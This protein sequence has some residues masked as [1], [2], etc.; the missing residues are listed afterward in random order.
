MLLHIDVE[1]DYYLTVDENGIYRAGCREFTKEEALEHWRLENYSNSVFMEYSKKAAKRSA[2]YCKAILNGVELKRIPDDL[3]YFTFYAHMSVPENLSTHKKLCWL[4]I[5]KGA[6]IPEGTVLP[7][8]L[9][10]IVVRRDAK[11][12]V[13]VRIPESVNR[14][15]LHG[16]AILRRTTTIPESCEIKRF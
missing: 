3:E 14:I 5:S 1:R 9:K 6:E 8:S 2:E 15:E 13:G 10:V 11:F 16:N 7:E 12:P 4:R